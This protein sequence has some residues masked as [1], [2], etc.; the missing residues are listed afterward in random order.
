MNLFDL[1]T[2][3]DDGTDV[4]QVTDTLDLSENQSDWV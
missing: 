3:S 2:M 4:M 1:Y